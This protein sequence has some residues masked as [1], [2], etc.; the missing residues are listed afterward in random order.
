MFIVTIDFKIKNNFFETKRDALIFIKDELERMEF[1]E[2]L[3]ELKKA[4][5]SQKKNEDTIYIGRVVFKIIELF[6]YHK[7]CIC[8]ENMNDQEK[9]GCNHSICK[10]CA[11]NLRNE[12]CPVC[13]RFVEGKNITDF[14]LCNILQRKEEDEQE[15]RN[16]DATMAFM[17]QLGE[18]PNDYY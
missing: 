7:C 14:V 17:V 1:G 12:K 13:K 3:K 16:H 4:K 2:P 8:Y 10:I 15:H 5:K 11:T 9:L 18:N 6:E